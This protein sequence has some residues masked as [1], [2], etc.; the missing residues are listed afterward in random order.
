MLTLY[1]GLTQRA[2]A[3]LLTQVILQR[4]PVLRVHLVF[5][6]C[7][8]GRGGARADRRA[9]RAALWTGHP[10]VRHHMVVVVSRFC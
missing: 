10:R 6:S 3:A 9:P 2:T 8:G 7:R 5:C 4:S 1:A